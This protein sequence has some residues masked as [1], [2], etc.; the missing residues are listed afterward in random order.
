MALIDM[1]AR[2]HWFNGLKDVK[3]EDSHAF[4]GSIHYCTFDSATAVISPIRVMHG[5]DEIIYAETFVVDKADIFSVYEYHFRPSGDG[6]KLSAGIHSMENK[7]LSE[8]KHSFLVEGLK[9]SCQTFKSFCEN[10]FR[11]LKE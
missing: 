11:P 4:V 1:A 10:G 8:S 2:V 9:T 6:C 7:S 3:Q 5:K